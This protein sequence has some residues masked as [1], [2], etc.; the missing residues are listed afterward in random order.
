MIMPVN[1]TSKSLLRGRLVQPLNLY[2]IIWLPPNGI[3]LALGPFLNH[4]L[5]ITF[6][7]PIFNRR[8]GLACL[9]PVNVLPDKYVC[10][11]HERECKWGKQ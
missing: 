4:V 10:G 1:V 2:I 5:L 6:L 8:L 11:L 9:E 7:K 3:H